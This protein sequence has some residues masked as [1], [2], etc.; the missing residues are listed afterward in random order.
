MAFGF[1]SMLYD[2][3]PSLNTKVKFMSHT[4][5]AKGTF[6]YDNKKLLLE[7]ADKLTK[8]LNMEKR[9]KEYIMSVC[10]RRVNSEE[11]VVNYYE[12]TLTIPEQ[13][14]SNL[15]RWIHPIIET[16][17]SKTLKIYSMEHNNYLVSLVDDKD[18]YYST[19]EEIAGLA[20]MATPDAI[21]MEC[22]D[23]QAKYNR[24]DHG[25]FVHQI[26]EAAYG[27]L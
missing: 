4:V 19:P 21:D 10:L 22:L 20:G 5:I 17:K 12:L 2:F 7:A 16:A 26:M 3:N 15:T 23:W 1:L 13:A 8:I 25:M 14:Y 11:S 24:G 6:K 9:G 18:F 27:R